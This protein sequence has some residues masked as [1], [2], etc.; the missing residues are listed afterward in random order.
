MIFLLPWLIFLAASQACAGFVRQKRGKKVLS[1]MKQ[2]VAI[3][4]R[5]FCLTNPALVA[6]AAPLS[7]AAAGVVPPMS[8]FHSLEVLLIYSMLK[9]LP[10]FLS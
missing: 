2:K 6:M 7:T 5:L 8:C 4:S 1:F 3:F 10:N 9:I